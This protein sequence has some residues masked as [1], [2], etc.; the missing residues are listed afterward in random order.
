MIIK[1]EQERE[2]LREGGRRLATILQ[3]VKE[4]AVP[5]TTTGELDDYAKELMAEYGDRPSFQGY[6]ASG[7][8]PPFPGALCTSVNDELVHGIPGERVLRDGDILKVDAGIWHEGLCTD[9]AI[10]I[11]IGTI[12]EEDAALMRATKEALEAQ[13]SVVR[14]G[15]TI[16]D[17]G[18]AAESVAREH[19]YGFPRELGGHGV[20]R[21]VHEEPFIFNY[22]TPGEGEVL[23]ENHVIA[24]E[25]MFAR[26]KGAIRLAPDHW[27]YYMKDNST[28]AHFEHTVIVTRNGAEVLTRA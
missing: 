15:V 17:I 26:G 10:T 21:A 4:R 12:D 14:A 20:G 24:L 2:A 5:G 9:S 22:G 23:L 28:G 1:T 16:G 8:T 6:G 19:G 25:P 18:H 11:G 27:T 13:I 7:S 3:K